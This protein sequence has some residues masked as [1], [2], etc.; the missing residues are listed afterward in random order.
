MKNTP[1]KLSSMFDTS[2]ESSRVPSPKI[3]NEPLRSPMRTPLRESS[4]KIPSSPARALALKSASF[5]QKHGR[6]WYKVCLFN[7]ILLLYL[8]ILA[9]FQ[10]MEKRSITMPC[11]QIFSNSTTTTQKEFCHVLINYDG[12]NL[13]E[14][15]TR[16]ND[17]DVLQA[18]KCCPN[19]QI[20]KDKIYYKFNPKNE[21]ILYFVS[22][23][24]SIGLGTFFYKNAL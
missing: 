14:P 8:G 15:T 18:V 20:L 21:F 10:I 4:P 23:L 22:I 11:D 17:I 5:A 2:S 9:I 13:A 7:A 1:Q 19:I 3:G 6:F 24:I 12:N 16:Y